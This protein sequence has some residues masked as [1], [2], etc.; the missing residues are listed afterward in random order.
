MT[1]SESTNPIKDLCERYNVRQAELARCFDI[2][3]RTVEDWHAGRR[4]PPSYVVNMIERLLEYEEKK[5]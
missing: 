1:K 2:P 3:L 5:K 4:K